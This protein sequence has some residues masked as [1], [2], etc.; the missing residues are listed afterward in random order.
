MGEGPIE[1]SLVQMYEVS[2]DVYYLEGLTKSSLNTPKYQLFQKTKELFS[3]ILAFEASAARELSLSTGNRAFRAILTWNEFAERL[4]KIQELDN[5]CER[6]Q[7]M[8]QSHNISSRL[9]ESSIHELKIQLEVSF[10]AECRR[11]DD[12]LK[13]EAKKILS[14]S[15]LDFET[16]HNEAFIKQQAGE[17]PIELSIPESYTKPEDWVLKSITLWINYYYDGN[18]VVWLFGKRRSSVK[19]ILLALHA[20]LESRWCWQ[21]IVDVWYTFHSLF[22]LQAKQVPILVLG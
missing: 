10:L 18:N 8:V 5:A 4:K 22:L 7:A 1:R 14:I 11:H 2:K 17:F 9:E 15:N 13:M 6:L 16:A 3:S 12:Q 20:N 19:Q 21:N